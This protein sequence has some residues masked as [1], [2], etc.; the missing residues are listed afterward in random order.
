MRIVFISLIFFS[1]ALTSGELQAKHIIGG[2]MYYQC[3]KLDT[4]R[5]TITIRVVLKMYRD[6]SNLQGAP[7]D[8]PAELGIYEKLANGTYRFITTETPGLGPV[9][10]IDPA[11]NNPCLIVPPNVCVQ[12]ASYESVITMPII[13]NSYYIAYQRCCRNETI[14][15]IDDPGSAGAAFTI[16]ITP[17]A[18][19]YCNN[20]PQFKN[21]PP[22]VI[23]VNYPLVFDHSAF[24]AEGDS[25]SYEFCNPLIAG[26]QDGS[27]NGMNSCVGVKP[28]PRNCRPPFST[29]SFKN[30]V[31]TTTLP[32]AGNP[33]IRIDSITGMITGKPNIQGQFVVG[34]CIKEYR[35]GILLTDTRRDF[36]FNV[37]FCEPKVFAKLQSDSLINGSKFIINSCGN[38]TIDFTNL[39][40]DE[41][42]ISSYQWTFDINGMIDTIFTKDARFTFPGLG[43]YT[44][45]MILNK[46]TNCSDTADISVNI[47]PAI[48]A[49]YTYSYDTCIA[50]PILFKDKS[51][52]GS[53][54]ITNWNWDFAN[55]GKSVLENPDFL[56]KTPGNKQVRLQV[57][58]INKCKADT[59]ATIPYFPVPPLLIVDPSAVDGC[60]P[61]KV[62]FNNLSVPIDST[63][64]ILWNFGDG[65]TGNQI[66][67]CHTYNEGGVYSLKLE[68]TSPIG[69]YIARDYPAWITTRKSPVA[70]FNFTP[71]QLSSLVRTARFDDLSTNANSREWTFNDRDKSKLISLDHTFRDTGLQKI[72]LIAISINGCRDTLVKYVDVEPKV[73]FYVPNAF[74]PNG[75]SSNDEFQGIGILD[76]MKDFQM[77]IWDRWGMKLFST[78]DP[79]VGWNGRLN[80]EGKDLPNGVYVF[81]IN[82]KTP[83][84][85]AIE[86][87]GFATLIR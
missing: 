55:A 71:S 41:Q 33:L 75:D 1:W 7:Y 84:D 80:N 65:N 4:V 15:N 78:N 86:I 40:T 74:T 69:C 49:G 44:G 77:T 39:S 2:D 9:N 66:S 82:Y 24:D 21:F 42:F 29:V 26:G 67:P 85:K 53:G 11:A 70:D 30:P 81:Q 19:K 6:C 56:F 13:N 51:I 20:S 68:V 16:E 50:G 17:E 10:L 79:L 3:L 52:S 5:H 59:I 14:S 60:T 73:T 37:A 35:K 27:S 32:M 57:T 31:Y 46:G 43:T 8:D 47:Y 76:G 23:C 18:Q 12:E 83:R 72:S 54:L 22:V 36:Q 87:K 25:I 48:N 61:L 38:R 34:V 64:K 62:C 63:Y 28:D 58:D 45:T